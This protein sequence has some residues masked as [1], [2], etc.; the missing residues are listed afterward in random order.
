MNSLIWIYIDQK[1]F[2]KSQKLAEYALAE[3]PDSRLFKWGLARSYE[4]DSTLE[5]I[6]IYYNI[7]DS[8]NGASLY[9]Y[10]L[11][12]H[13]IAQQYFRLG[14]YEKALKLCNDILSVKNISKYLEDRLE[15]RIERV[16][17]LKKYLQKELSK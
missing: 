7:L 8:Y 14:D 9:N 4:A 11:I 1:K 10:I 5:S 3:F 6:K 13:I 16:K 12:K 2:T 17:S 15:K